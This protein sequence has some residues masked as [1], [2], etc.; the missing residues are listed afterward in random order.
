MPCNSNTLRRG[1]TPNSLQK[2]CQEKLFHLKTLDNAELAVWNILRQAA[3]TSDGVV[4]RI[5]SNVRLGS[6]ERLDP[7]K[8]QFFQNETLAAPAMMWW[9]TSW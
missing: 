4:S 8:D 1:I 7:N 6:E 9:E 3:R 2:A 5:E